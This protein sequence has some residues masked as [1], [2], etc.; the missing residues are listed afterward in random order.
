MERKS[1]K[2]KILFTIPNFDTAGSGKAL[3]NIA[4]RLNNIIFEPHI[5]CLHDQG[6]YF[7]VVKESGIPIH[8]FEFTHPMTQRI[9]GICHCW[10]VSMHMKKIKPHLIHSFHYASDYSEALSAKMAGI[11]NQVLSRSYAILEDLLDNNQSSTTISEVQF[12]DVIN[13]EN[14]IIYNKLK[15]KLDSI[16]INNITPVEAIIILGELINEINN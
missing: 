4:S 6:Q 8:V 15:T 3:L 16:D 5:A 10:E 7:K 9:K 1:E 12:E 2:I 13:D 11:P 14:E